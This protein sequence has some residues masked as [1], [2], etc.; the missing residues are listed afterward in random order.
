MNRSYVLCRL[1]LVALLFFACGQPTVNAQGKD[2]KL[3]A[4]LIWG[5]DGEKPAEAKIKEV[6]RETRDKLKG[7]FR[8]KNYF[9]VSRQEFRVATDARRR[10]QMSKN[11]AIEVEY[12]G[13]S[14]IEVKLYGED[15]LL[16][17]KRQ[18]LRPGE[19][20]VLAGDDK[21]DTAWF[22][23]LTLAKN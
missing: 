13:R 23:I 22:V 12:H 16:L 8:W 2:L 17:T 6:D 5:T 1:S 18:I 7:V 10:V 11:C 3:V 9:E 4:Q 21:D 14:V 19:F 15:K 20:L